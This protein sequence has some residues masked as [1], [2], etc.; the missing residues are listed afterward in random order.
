M[1]T[2]GK[3]VSDIE[4]LKAVELAKS[5]G[6]H[7]AHL[8]TGYAVSAIE[9]WTK[10]LKETGAVKDPPS[11]RGKKRKLSESEETRIVKIARTKKGITNVALAKRM[12]S[13]IAPRTVSDV[14]ARSDRKFSLQLTRYDKP[15]TF[16]HKHAEQ[17]KMFFHHVKRIPAA[18]RVYVDETYLN[19]STRRKRVRAPVGEPVEE[20]LPS[21]PQETIVSAIRREAVLPITTIFPVG[22]IN[23]VQF[24]SWVKKKLCPCLRSGD[25]VIWDRLGKY[26]R[27]KKPYRLHYCPEARAA[28]EAR[29][30]KLLFLPPCGKLFNPIELLFR[31]CKEKYKARV[32]PKLQGWNASKISAKMMN[33]HYKQ[34]EREI[35][36]NQL[37]HYFRE[38]ANG[39]EFF[40]VCEQRGLL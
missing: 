5:V 19:P 20:S 13:K 6:F 10:L 26:G 8:K 39:K 14:L 17:G 30:A 28:L 7:Q 35:T 34:A 27:E 16:T 23:T 4:R 15:L 36:N 29:G 40:K 18:K 21:G 24:T 38:R 32:A 33:W 2:Q 12:K 1:S 3:P 25:V 9:K 11:H 31:D 22:C 37:Q